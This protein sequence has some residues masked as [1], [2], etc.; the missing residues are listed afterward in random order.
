MRMLVLLVLRAYRGFPLGYGMRPP[1]LCGKP[2][3]KG[4]PYIT[5]SS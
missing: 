1:T 3:W 2:S 5:Y 4:R